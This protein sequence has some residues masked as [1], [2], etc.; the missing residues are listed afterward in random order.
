MSQREVLFRAVVMALCLSTP[1]LAAGTAHKPK[2][3]PR[4]QL[5][6]SQEV[7]L[8]KAQCRK[9]V[10]ARGSFEGV[11]EGEECGEGC[12]AAFRLDSGEQAH[13]GCGDA[14]RL[15]GPAGRRVVAHF[16]V[17][18]AWLEYKEQGWSGCTEEMVCVKPPASSRTRSGSRR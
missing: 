9:A 4:G 3:L 11:Y 6:K 7:K 18:R 2:T 1:A 8:S 16:E 17:R 5:H 15:Y 14:D 13:L 10:I 12:S